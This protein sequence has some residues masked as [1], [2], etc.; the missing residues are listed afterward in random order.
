MTDLR[1]YEN[2]CSLLLLCYLP[3]FGQKMR[4]KLLM[5]TVD[6]KT[7]TRV[8]P[9]IGSSNSNANVNCGGYAGCSGTASGSSVYMPAH[10]QEVDLNHT[11]MLL[12]LPDGRRVG[13]YCN[14]HTVGLTRF[15]NCKKPEVD[16][17]EA[18]FSGPK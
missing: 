6:G 13:V 16:E 5:K 17:F 11:E 12:L 18:D 15:H 9:G 3:A 10:T 4:V 7:Y 2:P 14:D 8:V 1:P